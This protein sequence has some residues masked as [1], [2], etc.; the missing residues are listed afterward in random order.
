[1]HFLCIQVEEIPDARKKIHLFGFPMPQRRPV[2]AVKKMLLPSD[3]T[4][5]QFDQLGSRFEDRLEVFRPQSK[6]QPGSDS[7]YRCVGGS[8]GQKGDFAKRVAWP[9]LLHLQDAS[10]GNLTCQFQDTIGNELDGLKFGSLC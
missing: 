6:K 7:H 9:N 3:S 10:I 8:T 4:P 5:D 2:E 1:M